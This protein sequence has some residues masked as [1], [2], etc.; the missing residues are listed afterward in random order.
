MLKPPPDGFNAPERNAFEMLGF[1]VTGAV[2]RIDGAT[3]EVTMHDHD[4]FL[5]T[6]KLPCCAEIT[7]VTPKSKILG[8]NATDDLRIEVERLQDAKRRALA[9]ADERAKETVALRAALARL[10][11]GRRCV[12]RTLTMRRPI[13]ASSRGHTRASLAGGA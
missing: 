4:H 12:N 1:T 7:A 10:C 8:N 11:Q 2:A 13:P 6:V 5:S 3:V 9:I